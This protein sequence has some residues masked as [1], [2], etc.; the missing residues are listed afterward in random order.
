[1]LMQ[2]CGSP[3][4]LFVAKI[5]RFDP[6]HTTVQIESTCM[7][8]QVRHE[9]LGYDWTENCVTCNVSFLVKFSKKPGIC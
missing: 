9:R 3:C 8:N 5:N 2:L 7:S 6:I 4:N 1:M